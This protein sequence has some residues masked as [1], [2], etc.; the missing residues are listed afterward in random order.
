MKLRDDR[1]EAM[2]WQI[3]DSIQMERV[4]LEKQ[5]QSAMLLSWNRR[6]ALLIQL[7]TCIDE[8]LAHVR[9]M[10]GSPSGATLDT[11]D[12]LDAS[13]KEVPS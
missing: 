4:E 3:K 5:V 12:L 1:V 13:K 10:R 11:P 6:Y 8:S 7:F 2:L 9:E